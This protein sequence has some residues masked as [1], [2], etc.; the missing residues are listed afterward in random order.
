MYLIHISKIEKMFRKGNSVTLSLSH[1]YI[2]KM[3]SKCTVAGGIKQLEHLSWS[4]LGRWSL[5][6]GDRRSYR[7]SWHHIMLHNLHVSIYIDSIYIDRAL[8]RLL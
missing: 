8:A 2:Y 3:Y 1:V 4:E 5:L 6:F 7:S